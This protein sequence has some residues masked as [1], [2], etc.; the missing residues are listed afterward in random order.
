MKKIIIIGGSGFI[1]QSLARH[2]SAAG[3]EVVIIARSRPTSLPESIRFSL[4]DGVTLG[5]WVDEF[6]NAYAV[7]NLAGRSVDCIKTPDNCDEILRS[8]V[9]STLTVGKALN[10]AVNPPNIW[11]QMSTAHIYGDPPSQLCTEDSP[12][13]YGLA[14]FVGKAWEEAFYS[15]VPKTC[16]YSILRTSFVIGKNGGA[17]TKLKLITRLG[18]GGKVGS[19]KQG[20]SWIHEYDMNEIIRTCIENESYSGMYIATAPNPVSQHEFMQTLRKEMNIRIGLPSPEFAIRLGARFL[21]KTDPELVLYGR[22]LKS[23]RLEEQEFQFRFPTLQ[24]ALK[25]LLS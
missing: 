16:R 19:G 5:T 2:C 11:I 3:Y 17:M 14:P 18:L 23:R 7:V 1:G 15:V 13:G 20:L 9:Q 22:Y 4:W 12:T 6:T 25:D 8:R 21:F 24:P 10:K